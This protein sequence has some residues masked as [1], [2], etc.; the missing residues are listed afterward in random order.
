MIREEKREEIKKGE[1]E[2]IVCSG[3][4]A[5][6]GFMCNCKRTR[7]TKTISKQMTHPLVSKS[8]S[9]WLQFCH[10]FQRSTTCQPVSQ[11]AGVSCD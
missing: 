5:Q 4:G 8:V 1:E 7:W 3:L 9:R 6:L 11:A 2:I 10:V